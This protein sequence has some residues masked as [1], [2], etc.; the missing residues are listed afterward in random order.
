LVTRRPL[1]MRL[2]NVPLSEAPKP[3]AIFE[4]IKG[5]KFDDFEVVR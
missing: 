4:E 3:Y 1:E 5:K 2:I